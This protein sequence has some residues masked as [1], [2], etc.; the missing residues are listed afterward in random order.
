[1]TAKVCVR[2]RNAGECIRA[3]T[4]WGVAMDTRRLFTARRRGTACRCRRNRR[5]RPLKLICFIRLHRASDYDGGDPPRAFYI[6]ARTHPRAR[7]PFLV[8][9]FLYPY[10]Y[11]IPH[12][13][14]SLSPITV[15]KREQ[16]WTYF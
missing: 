12:L 1:M 6:Y 7:T 8:S 5:G 2:T 3:R 13:S 15:P 9:L 14:H 11:F 10:F 4:G 16:H